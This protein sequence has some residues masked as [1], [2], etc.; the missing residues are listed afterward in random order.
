MTLNRDNDYRCLEIM[1]SIYL[2]YFFSVE[3][4]QF[5]RHYFLSKQN[6]IEIISKSSGRHSYKFNFL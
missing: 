2:I 1:N 5:L 6:I 4:Y 3:V